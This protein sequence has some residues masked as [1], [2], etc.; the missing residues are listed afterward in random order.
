MEHL[1]LRLLEL[2]PKDKKRLLI[3]YLHPL[4]NI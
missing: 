1:K 3:K 2:F 4:T